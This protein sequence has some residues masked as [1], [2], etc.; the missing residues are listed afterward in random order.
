MSATLVI[1][2]V[3]IDSLQPAPYNP[4]DITD[5]SF[6]GLK[7]SLKKFGMVEPLIVNVRTGLLVGGHQRLKAAGAIG[8]THIPIVEVDLSPAE[9]RALNVTL[10]NPRIAGH[11]TDNLSLLLDE[12]KLDLGEPM[13]KD[14]RLDDLV[15]QNS[16]DSVDKDVSDTEENLN[17]IMVTIKVKC[18]Q[19]VKA[20]I[21]DLIKEALD[22]SG[23]SGIEVS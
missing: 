13:I 15:I 7:E 8:L 20:D 16:W 3:P 10:N 21:L 2:H 6:E 14:L 4:R 18:L 5:A 11:F 23:F 12:I 17:G 19:E 9:E 1:K 22:Q